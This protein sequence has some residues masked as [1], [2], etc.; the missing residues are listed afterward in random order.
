ME[1]IRT[2]ED[3]VTRLALVRAIRGTTHQT[4]GHAVGVD[5][6]TV[7][8]WERGT[9]KPLPCQVKRLGLALGWPWTDLMDVPL[10]YDDAWTTLLNARKAASEAV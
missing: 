5:A 1:L 4:L 7:F 2:N 9:V 6:T 10:P 3:Q 8:R